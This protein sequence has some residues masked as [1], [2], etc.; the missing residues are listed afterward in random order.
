MKRIVFVYGTLKK[1]ERNHRL[2]EG[3]KYLR[4]AWVDG[5][6]CYG[7]PYGFPAIIPSVDLLA[8]QE[9]WT[10]GQ[11]YEV[12]EEVEK[13]L[14]M[15]EGYRGEGNPSNMYNKVEGVAER[16]VMGS[17]YQEREKINVFFYVW[18]GELPDGAEEVEENEWFGNKE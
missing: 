15:L 14:D 11:L 12:D 3:C 8:S 5:Y 7:L 6:V 18:N 9:E 4:Q 13:K 17:D 1:G 2:L 16:F 10:M